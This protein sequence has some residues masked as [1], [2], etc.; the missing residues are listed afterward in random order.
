MNRYLARTIDNIFT[1]FGS[2]ESARRLRSNYIVLSRGNVGADETAT[3]RALSEA[4]RRSKLG[5]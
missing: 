4:V 2:I 3:S 1:I 5:R